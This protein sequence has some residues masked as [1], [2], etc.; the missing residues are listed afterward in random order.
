[1][2]LHDPSA[3]GGM[4][5]FVRQTDWVARETRTNPPRPGVASVRMPGDRGLALRATQLAEGVALHPTIPG[6]LGDCAGRYGLQ[7]PVP[8]GGR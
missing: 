8:L 2:T 4:A 7:L 6:L 1:M 5:D 3:F